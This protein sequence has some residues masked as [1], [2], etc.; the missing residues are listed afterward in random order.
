MLVRRSRIP[1]AAVAAAS[2]IAL[3]TSSCGGGSSPS[4]STPTTTLPSQPTPTP[5]PTGNDSFNHSSCPFGKGSVNAECSQGGSALLGEMEEAMDLLIKQKPQIFD[6]GEEAGPGTKA[7]RVLDR[8]AYMEG[9]VANL[10]AAGLCAERDPD[11]AMLETIRAKNSNDFSEEFDVLLSNGFMRRGGGAY[12]KTCNPSS[13][14]VERSADAPPIGSGCGRPYP[15]PITRF[16][17]KLHL[18]G[19]DH[20]TLDSTPQ[21]GPDVAYCAS[22]GFTDGRSICPV[23]VEG[24]PDRVACENWLVGRARDTGRYGPTWTKTDGGFCTGPASGCA[25]HPDSQYQ[26][27]TYASGTYSVTAE[28]GAS[29]KVVVEQ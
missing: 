11:D 13:F 27:F 14:P 6:L 12:R 5:P 24:T 9:L 21:V 23:R 19:S 10:R 26:L 18:K 15:P 22:I 29:C 8:Q 20:Y 7:Y 25:N 16:G 2:L 4:S 3:L 28:N 17:C 1:V